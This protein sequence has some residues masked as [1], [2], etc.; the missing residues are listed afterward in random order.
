M[1]GDGWLSLRARDPRLISTGARRELDGS[2]MGSRVVR[3]PMLWMWRLIGSAARRPYLCEW[4][5]LG[6]ARK[7]PNLHPFFGK[8]ALKS[9]RTAVTPAVTQWSRPV[10]FCRNLCRRRPHPA[11]DELVEPR[12]GAVHTASSAAA[13]AAHALRAAGQYCHLGDAN[14]RCKRTRGEPYSKVEGE[15]IRGQMGSARCRKRTHYQPAARPFP[16]RPA[17]FH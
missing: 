12:H 16:H 17:C 4:E 7:E 5:G 8:L 3:T 15:R 14:S 10:C 2:S 11:R 9:S 1:L 13:A 6:V